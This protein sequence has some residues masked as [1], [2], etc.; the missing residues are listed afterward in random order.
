MSS[1]K[2]GGKPYDAATTNSLL[3]GRYKSEDKSFDSVEEGGWE[4]CSRKTNNRAAS[5]AEKYTIHQNSNHR[6]W[7]HLNGQKVGLRSNRRGSGKGPSWSVRPTPSADTRG[8]ISRNQ[9]T[10]IG[11]ANYYRAPSPATH[12]PLEHGSRWNS[13]SA[14][15]LFPENR[16]EEVSSPLN[17]EDVEVGE[18]DKEEKDTDEIDESDDEL[19]SDNYDSD[20]SQKSHGTRKKSKWF[21]S[22]FKEF[23]SLTIEQINEVE[24]RR[25]CPACRG[26]PGAVFWYYGLQ[27]LITHAKTKGSR[28][29]A[30]HREFA[31]VLEEELVRR[32]TNVVPAGEAFGKWKGLSE[33]TADKEIV[34]PP[35][36]V[37]MNTQLNKDDKGQWTGMGSPELLDYFGAYAAVKARHAYG[38]D[39]HRGMSLLIF[40]TSAVGYLEA[41]RLSNHFEDEGTDREAWVSRRMARMPLYPGAGMKRQLFGYMAE[42]E[43]LDVFNQHLH[44]KNKLKF[45]MRSYQDMV[46]KKIKQMSEENQ[47]LL[48][49]K[50]RVNKEQKHSKALEESLVLVSEKYRKTAEENRIVRERVKMHNQQNKEEMDAQDEFFKDQMKI[51]HEARGEN[52]ENFERIQQEEREKVKQSCEN[53]SLVEDP[54]RRAEEFANFITCQDKEMNNFVEEREKLIKAHE[55]EKVELKRRYL[56]EEVELEEKLNAKLNQ[57]MEKYTPQYS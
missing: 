45:D 26:G 39:G 37:I 4:V 19:L 14:S 25:H 27:A 7:G 1:S 8:P 49:F 17:V 5:S 42:K 15:T 16:Q 33:V 48:W 54:R 11:I 18:D 32:G 2:G 43:D 10:N 9:S 47:E 36:V 40:E 21:K 41:E 23:D 3:N 52:E 20:A 56:K 29:V 50:N 57:L 51:I 46:V 28:R 24:R 31:E 22:F 6:D 13:G 12:P 38:P 30:L 44:G 35:M 55:D 53:P 34:W